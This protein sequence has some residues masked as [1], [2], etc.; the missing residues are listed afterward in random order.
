MQSNRQYKSGG[1]GFNAPTPLNTPII[2]HR[3]SDNI[4]EKHLSKDEIIHFLDRFINEKESVINGGSNKT[5]NNGEEN[6][7]I[8]YGVTN[9]DTNLISSLSQLKR[10]LRDFKG[11]PSSIIEHKT[12]PACTLTPVVST[13]YSG[14]KKT[15]DDDD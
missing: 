8:N 13:V 10:I 4:G 15:F 14:T 11:L 2:I 7:V 6:S 3:K 9:V 1:A 5:G 12:V